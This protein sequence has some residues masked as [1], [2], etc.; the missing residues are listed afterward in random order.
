[1]SH[2][3]PLI[4]FFSVLISIFMETLV[5]DFCGVGVGAEY[6]HSAALAL[7][8]VLYGTFA[9]PQNGYIMLV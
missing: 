1:M 7:L 3:G 4:F 8:L 2:F 9:C 5:L 6:V